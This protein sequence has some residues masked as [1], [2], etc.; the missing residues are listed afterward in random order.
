MPTWHAAK[1][2]ANRIKHGVE[3]RDAQRVFDAPHVV[4]PDLRANYREPRFLAFG[5]AGAACL[6]VVFTFRNGE[7][8]IISAR[9][10]S[11]D[12][13]ETIQP[14]LAEIGQRYAA[15]EGGPHS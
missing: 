14:A 4:F 13:I 2:R 11:Q 6:V 1:A 8:R 10:A 9:K 7:R 5:F 3:F 12:E 15:R